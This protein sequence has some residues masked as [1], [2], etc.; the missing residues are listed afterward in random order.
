MTNEEILM[1]FFKQLYNKCINQEFV[2][3]KSG[4]KIAEIW[5]C[6]IQGLSPLQP[7]LEFNG[8]KSPIDYIDRKSVV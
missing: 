7:I 4:V 3:D 2:K 1:P 5:D 6:H 8:R